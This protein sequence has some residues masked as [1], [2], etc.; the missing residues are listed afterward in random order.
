MNEFFRKPH[1]AVFTHTSFTYRSVASLYDSEYCRCASITSRVW[2]HDMRLK[3]GDGR[4]V[5]E[6]HR[7]VGGQ[8]M[9]KTELYKLS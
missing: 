7:Y 2:F 8:S 9:V 4:T 5:G 6:Y 1:F 3:V